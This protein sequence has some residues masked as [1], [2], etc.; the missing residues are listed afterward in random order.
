MTS[1]LL[2]RNSLLFPVWIALFVAIGCAY[3]GFKF[4]ALADA[5]EVRF[6]SVE[7]QLSAVDCKQIK[8]DVLLSIARQSFEAPRDNAK[9]FWSLAE[10]FFVMSVLNLSFVWK[11]LRPKPMQE[12][13]Q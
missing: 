9:I 7:Q 1:K 6:K 12:S 10:L 2:L 3:W 13:S 11:H 5:K 4:E 8:T